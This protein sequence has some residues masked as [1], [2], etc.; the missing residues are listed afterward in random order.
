MWIYA[1][2][3]VEL[4]R[5]RRGPDQRF[6]GVLGSRPLEIAVPLVEFAPRTRNVYSR[7]QRPVDLLDGHLAIMPHCEHPA[8]TP[9]N[10]HGLRIV[11]QPRADA[12]VAM[13]VE[14]ALTRSSVAACR[15]PRLTRR[16]GGR[17]LRSVK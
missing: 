11:R 2:N 8:A 12:A 7:T 4:Q 14:V 5:R 13:V 9:A 6:R 1:Q 15:R 17:R 16:L 3:L 10:P